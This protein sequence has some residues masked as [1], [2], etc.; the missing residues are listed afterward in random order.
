MLITQITY[1][2]ELDK[3]IDKKVEQ[4]MIQYETERGIDVNYQ[5]FYLI[6][7]NNDDEIV[8]KFKKLL[9]FL[10]M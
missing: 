5:Q 10:N 7:H 1:S 6:S 2:N 4:G 3:A 9:I 8:S